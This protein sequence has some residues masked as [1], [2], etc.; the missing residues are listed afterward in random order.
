M[1]ETRCFRPF[2]FI[3]STLSPLH[4]LIHTLHEVHDAAH[5]NCVHFISQ[6]ITALSVY[7]KKTNTI[8]V[9]KQISEKI[10]RN[11]GCENKYCLLTVK[12][13]KSRLQA[14][15]DELS[16]SFFDIIS[17][18]TWYLSVPGR[19]PDYIQRPVS[20]QCK[21]KTQE[22]PVKITVSPSSKSQ[23]SKYLTL[24]DDWMCICN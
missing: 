5:L 15:T 1:S 10:M 17:L 12:T 2:P 21:N 13:A 23:N 24:M 22:V 16:V 20:I 14:S 11:T 7:F 3:D 4:F 18:S 6:F 8:C 19:I 9:D